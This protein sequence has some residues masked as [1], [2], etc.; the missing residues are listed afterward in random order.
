MGLRDAAGDPKDS[1]PAREKNHRTQAVAP[2]EG[3]D[4]Q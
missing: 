1:L 2:A 3:F 4:R